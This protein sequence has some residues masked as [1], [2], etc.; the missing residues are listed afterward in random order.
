MEPAL[1]YAS[2]LRWAILPV[3]TIT[4]DRRCSCGRTECEDPGK[5]PRTLHGLNDA[6]TDPERIRR[7]WTRWPMANIGVRT[8]EASGID[9]LDID[10]RHGGDD[11]LDELVASS[12][13]S[14]RTVEQLTGGGGRHLLF[15]HRPGMQ[16]SVGRLPGIDVRGDGAYVVVAPS[17]HV[18]G[19]R[20]SWELSS[21]PGEVEVA[22]WPTSWLKALRSSGGLVRA[23]A[24]PVKDQIPTGRRNETLAS[25]AG[26]MRRRGMTE[27][28]IQ[29]ALLV[30]NE[31][32]CAP[33]L[34]EYEVA[35]IAQSVARYAPGDGVARVLMATSDPERVAA[36]ELAKGRRLVFTPASSIKMRPTGWIWQD[37]DGGRIPA[38]EITLTAGLGGIG[39]STFHAW[40][41]GQITTGTLPG[42]HCGSPSACIIS[43]N[44][45][46]WDRTIV[47]RLVAAGADLDLVYRVDVVEESGQAESLSLPADID[48]LATE[49]TAR[50]VVLVSLDPVMSLIASDIDSHKDQ[51]VRKALEPLKRLAADTGCVILGNAHFNKGGSADPMMRITGSAAFGQV[52]RAVLAFAADPE[53]STFVIS[54]PKNNLGQH[55]PPSLAYL[56]ESTDITTDEGLATVGRL[57]FVGEAP[58]SV[59]DVLGD[60]ANPDDRSALE[61]AKEWLHSVLEAG[62]MLKAEILAFAR[63]EAISPRT[64]DRAMSELSI[65]SERDCSLRGRPATWRLPGF[66]P[67]VTRQNL[68]ADNVPT[69]SSEVAHSRNGVSRRPTE[70]AHNP[71]QEPPR[72]VGVG[73]EKV[74]L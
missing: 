1:F 61:D 32:R 16:S 22:E 4:D 65:I 64:L 44:E 24:S 42:I 57:V 47:P 15:R 21:L 51:E 50:Q 23:P 36:P 62:P 10:P 9:V 12:G 7:W 71:I 11:S 25:L 66:M 63:K 54:Q 33:P 74:T 55:D 59:R 6:S 73:R 17:S 26:T 27:E 38:G 56:I 35:S 45:D 5:H 41:I 18:S 72:A 14:P 28:E 37:E 43:A 52:V 69:Q 19:Q 2:S 3:H 34:Q 67:M 60:R 40:I 58:R 20:Y 8:G 30:A 31:R 68:L 13:E 29:A 39:K 53:A 48:A 49:I 70:Q 46:S